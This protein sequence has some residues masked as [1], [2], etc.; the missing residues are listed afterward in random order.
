MP[1]PKS[2]I[3]NPKSESKSEIRNPKS[4]APD[5]DFGFG[6]SDFLRERSFA[7]YRRF[8]RDHYDGLPGRSPP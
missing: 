1:N 3:R 6:S 5:S 8:V 4:E 2:E 7:D